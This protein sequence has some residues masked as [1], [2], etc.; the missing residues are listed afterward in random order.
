MKLSTAVWLFM[1]RDSKERRGEEI[2]S[3]FLYSFFLSLVIAIAVFNRRIIGL[4]SYTRKHVVGVVAQIP[5]WT[6]CWSSNTA[7]IPPRLKNGK[8]NWIQFKNDKV[9]YQIT[10]L[11]GI[12]LLSDIMFVCTI[13]G[14]E[15][16]SNEYFAEMLDTTMNE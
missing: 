7:K 5:F 13:F 10:S 11:I 9:N 1:T 12:V 6:P 2:Y 15:S 8:R 4:N 16:S 14:P 3:V